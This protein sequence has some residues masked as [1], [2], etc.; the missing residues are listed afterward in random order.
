M[1][2]TTTAQ[3]AAETETAAKAGLRLNKQ[4]PAQQNRKI[5]IEVL[6]FRAIV[7]TQTQQYITYT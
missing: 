4:R 1:R 3:V 5:T 6:A 2:N 7:G